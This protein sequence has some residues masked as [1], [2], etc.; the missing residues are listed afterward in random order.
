MNK[1]NNLAAKHNFNRPV[2]HKDR[3][4]ASRDGSRK[5]KHKFRII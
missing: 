4:R 5:Q 2:V 3:K 1:I